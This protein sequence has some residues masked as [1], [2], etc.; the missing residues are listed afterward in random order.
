M[1]YSL[2]PLL[3]LM[4]CV[5]CKEKSGWTAYPPDTEVSYQ[6]I[7]VDVAKD[8]LDHRPEVIFLDVRT[9]EEISQGMVPGAQTA[10]VKSSS[11]ESKIDLLDPHKE[12]IVYCRSGKRS[13]RAS[14]VMIEKGFTKVKNMEGG[15]NAWKEKYD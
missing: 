13:V 7:T 8:I 10:D 2:V 11:F 5:S 14:K 4:I 15:Y 1:K 12:Y 9:P 3:A 6:D